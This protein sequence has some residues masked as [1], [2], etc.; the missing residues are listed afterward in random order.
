[1]DESRVIKP[2]FHLPE[3][4]MLAARAEEMLHSG[5]DF[6]SVLTFLRSGGLGKLDSMR[7]L[8]NSTGLGLVEAKN[9]VQASKAWR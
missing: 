4:M 6:E 7:V 1:M 2:G 8:S 5:A 3:Q 9:I